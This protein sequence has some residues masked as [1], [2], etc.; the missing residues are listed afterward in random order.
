[1]ERHTL[2]SRAQRAI[3]AALA[4]CAVIAVWSTWDELP[5]R[6]ASH[7]DASGRPDGYMDR[8]AFFGQLA[9]VGGAVVLLLASVPALLRVVP[10]AALNIP[11]RD[12]WLAAERREQSLRRLGAACGWCAVATA[13]LLLLVVALTLQ[14]NL[15]RTG[16]HMPT[17]LVGFGLYLASLTMVLI[18]LHRQFARPPDSQAPPQR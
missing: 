4:A 15:A 16:L 6:M 1:M 2:I 12:Y 5:S 11:H 18:R 17:F 3:L 13:V 7:F 14:A 10:S 9:A 8:G